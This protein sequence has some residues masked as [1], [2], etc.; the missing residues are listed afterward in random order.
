MLGILKDK[1]IALYNRNKTIQRILHFFGISFGS[2]L[3][4]LSIPATCPCCG[5]TAAACGTSI[6][7][8]GFIGIVA[9]I[10]TQGWRFMKQI[11][12]KIG[13][14]NLNRN[15]TTKKILEKYI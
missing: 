14:K 2:G 1:C 10:I 6:F 11:F 9:G 8:A 5:Q 7:A 4:Y 12:S 13:H 3:L 15:D